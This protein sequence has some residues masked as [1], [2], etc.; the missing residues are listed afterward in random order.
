LILPI[1][2]KKHSFS[3]VEI[4]PDL[5]AK[6]TLLFILFLFYSSNTFAQPSSIADNEESLFIDLGT[7]FS[8]AQNSFT[9]TWDPYPSLD[10]A[11]RP[12]LY[13]GYLEAGARFTRFEGM[14]P[15]ATDSDF[16]SLFLY[17]GWSY[18]FAI[19]SRLSIAPAIRFGNNLMIFDQAEVFTNESGSQRFVTDTSENE[20][21]Y[22][23]A[24]R[25]QFQLAG[26]W[27]IH[28]ELSYNRTITEFPLPA[29][30]LSAGLSYE[31]PQPNWLKSILR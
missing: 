12:A 18:P 11:L 29:G 21:A 7:G 2:T 24:L 28:A 1:D 22:E 16:S 30:L 9:N 23:L 15:T 20:F 5:I 14:A 25:S 3:E 6:R 10:F 27:Y 13:N 19:S 31:I 26:R 17:M 8:V 4:H